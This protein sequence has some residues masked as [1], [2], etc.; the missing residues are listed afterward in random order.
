[1]SNCPT[2]EGGDHSGQ[3]GFFQDIRSAI[4]MIKTEV[5]EFAVQDGESLRFWREAFRQGPD[6]QP[7]G[8]RARCTRLRHPGRSPRRTAGSRGRGWSLRSRT[9]AHAPARHF[10]AGNRQARAGRL[11]SGSPAPKQS[12]QL[13]DAS[14]QSRRFDFTDS[15][16]PRGLPVESPWA[17]LNFLVNPD[18]RLEGRKPIDVLRSG[19]VGEVIEAARLYGEPGG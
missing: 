11:S 12:P 17:V 2:T 19:N 6:N 9:G 8:L 16:R 10:Q 3:I 13:S 14:V 1:M 15:R 18:D 7:G 5:E 4:R